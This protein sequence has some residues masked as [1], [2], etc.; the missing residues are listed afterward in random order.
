MKV[1]HLSVYGDGN[2]GLCQAAT[3]VRCHIEARDAIV[4]VAL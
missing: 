3:D 2:S 1:V 4:V